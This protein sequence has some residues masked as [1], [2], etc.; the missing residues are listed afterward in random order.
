MPSVIVLS[1]LRRTILRCNPL[2]LLLLFRFYQRFFAADF[3]AVF[4]LRLLA[5]ALRRLPVTLLRQ[6]RLQFAFSYIG[7]PVREAAGG[8]V[9]LFQPI[10]LR[11]PWPFR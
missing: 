5:F 10:W 6:R 4:R 11:R 9:E 1:L 8:S 2:L 7:R 3:A